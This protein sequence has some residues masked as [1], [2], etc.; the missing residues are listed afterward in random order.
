[1]NISSE[2]TTVD[3]TGYEDWSVAAQLCVGEKTCTEE[4]RG[5]QMPAYAVAIL[6]PQK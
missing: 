2:G 1:M 5:L 6:L 3:L 4:D